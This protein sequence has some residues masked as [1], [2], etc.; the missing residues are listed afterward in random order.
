MPNQVSC[1]NSRGAHPNSGQGRGNFP[2]GQAEAPKEC[3][4]NP[5]NACQEPNKYDTIC[6]RVISPIANLMR[7]RSPNQRNISPLYDNLNVFNN[8]MRIKHP[9]RANAFIRT[10]QP[11]LCSN[12]PTEAESRSQNCQFS[13]SFN[14]Q[15][16]E[17]PYM[18]FK[19]S[20]QT[21]HVCQSVAGSEYSYADTIKLKNNNTLM[22]VKDFKKAG[23]SLERANQATVACTGN[24]QGSQSSYDPKNAD[25]MRVLSVRSGRTSQSQLEEQ[26][27][28]QYQHQLILSEIQAQQQ[29]Q[30]LRILNQKH[31]EQI[32]YEQQSKQ[33]NQP[34]SPTIKGPEHAPEQQPSAGAK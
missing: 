19:K 15:D 18:F 21:P 14:D 34:Q 17:Q 9:Q 2:E 27:I 6:S 33:G 12:Y 11:S 7:N 25:S 4:S 22:I 3:G 23:S 1:N 8:R 30:Y 20:A 26:L 29:Q 13:I 32:Q 16:S 10:R 28:Q 5:G 31:K 24:N